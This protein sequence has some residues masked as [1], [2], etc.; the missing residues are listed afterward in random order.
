MDQ[1]PVSCYPV[2]KMSKAKRVLEEARDS[3]NPEL[4][5]AD[6]SI[7]N[8]EEMP[9]LRELWHFFYLFSRLVAA[10]AL[11]NLATCSRAHFFLSSSTSYDVIRHNKPFLSSAVKFVA[12]EI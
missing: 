12:Q 3:Q 9:G 7:V 5:L 10:V 6:K 1:A 2:A 11:P 4:D 8:F